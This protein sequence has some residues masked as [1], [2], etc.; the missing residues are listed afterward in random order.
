MESNQDLALTQQVQALAA[1]IE[2][3]IQSQLGG[4]GR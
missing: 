1:T 3:S 2:E 4:W